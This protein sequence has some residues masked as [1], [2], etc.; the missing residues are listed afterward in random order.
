MGRNDCPFHDSMKNI[1]D[2]MIAKALWNLKQ[3]ERTRH[4]NEA[5]KPLEEP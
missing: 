3:I 1:D 2:K 5:G 4:F